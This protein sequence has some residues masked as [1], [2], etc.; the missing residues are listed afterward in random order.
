MFKIPL[1][2]T[3]FNRKH[4]APWKLCLPFVD[5]KRA[6]LIHRPRSVTTYALLG[7]HYEAVEMWCGSGQTGRDKFDFQSTPTEGKLLCSRCEAKAVAAGLPSASE[8]AGR[9]VHEGKVVPV[10]TCC[11]PRRPEK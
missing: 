10:R 11:N 5:N 9:H 6:L 7:K 1:R 8:I 2:I 4:G 3:P